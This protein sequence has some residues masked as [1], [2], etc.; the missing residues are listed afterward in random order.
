MKVYLLPAALLAAISLFASSQMLS[1]EKAQAQYPQTLGSLLCSSASGA[2][3]AG[4]SISVSATLIDSLGQ[5]V[6]GQIVVFT[7]TGANG[8]LSQISGIT[9][10]FGT[11]NAV[12]GPVP[13]AVVVI[14]ASSGGMSCGVRLDPLITTTFFVPQT[15]VLPPPVV[16]PQ[17]VPVRQVAAQGPQ[18]EVAGLFIPPI[19]GDAGLA[20]KG[21][22]EQYLTLALVLVGLAAAVPA[23][24]ILLRR[25]ARA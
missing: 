10:A 8:Y 15:F 3:V 11:A 13:G 21:H 23:L 17:A 4:G 22:D 18:Q 7:A 24:C 14:T 2:F 25:R 16:I 1:P 9:N 20:S 12:F 5:P 6:A 19:V